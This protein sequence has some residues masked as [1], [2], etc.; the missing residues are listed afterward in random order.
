MHNLQVIVR[1]ADRAESEG[2]DHRDPDKAIGEIRPQ[3]GRDQHA[4]DNEHAAHGGS[5]GFLLMRLRP[6]LA[7]VLANLELAQPAH[8]RG[9][10]DQSDEQRGQAGK[11]SAKCEVT[12]DSERA[13]MEDDESLLVEQPI[14]QILS[15]PKR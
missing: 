2:G 12:K 3:Q 7:N 9:A 11:G 14:E 15:R 6:L 4:D 10:Y 13:D 5:A 1:E 8:D